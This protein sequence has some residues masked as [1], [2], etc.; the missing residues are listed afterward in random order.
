MGY[1]S[2]LLLSIRIS[3]GIFPFL[4]P[5]LVSVFV[6]LLHLYF[7]ATAPSVMKDSFSPIHKC[8]VS[9]QG[10]REV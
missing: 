9:G 10:C 8:L 6:L 2:V 3:V 4:W 5:S 1:I 7:A